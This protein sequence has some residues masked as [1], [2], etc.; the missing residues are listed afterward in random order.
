MHFAV[1]ISSHRGFH[2]MAGTK[3]HRFIRFAVV[4][5]DQGNPSLSEVPIERLE[6]IMG[7]SEQETCQAL[8]SNALEWFEFK[9]GS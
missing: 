2:L 5:N 3:M 6:G 9:T 7:S 8:R 4:E 1:R